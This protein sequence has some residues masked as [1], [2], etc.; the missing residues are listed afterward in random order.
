[1]PMVEKLFRMKRGIIETVNDILMTLCDI[2]HIRHSSPMK[3]V[4]HAYTGVAAYTNL[5]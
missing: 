4:A 1:M 5:D 2:D 3:A